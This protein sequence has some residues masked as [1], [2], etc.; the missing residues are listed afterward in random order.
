MQEAAYP[1]G[2][3]KEWARLLQLRL[4]PQLGGQSGRG[5]EL[6]ILPDGEVAYVLERIGPPSMIATDGSI[7]DSGVDQAEVHR[8]LRL[9]K[10][11]V[12]GRRGCHQPAP[13]AF[14]RRLLR[15][16]ETP[17]DILDPR[18]YGVRTLWHRIGRLDPGP[19]GLRLQVR[20]GLGLRVAPACGVAGNVPADPNGA[21]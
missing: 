17:R 8:V 13:G 3:C 10:A 1:V 20:P 4:P 14:Q 9:A 2:L 5:P 7:G 12:A 19:F 21:L 6:P 18:L 16:G 15:R 11:S